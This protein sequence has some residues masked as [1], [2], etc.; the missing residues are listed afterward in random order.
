MTI[1]PESIGVGKCYLTDGNTVRRV[2]TVL[3]DRRIQYEWRGGHRA[4]WKA[5]ILSGR[6]FAQQ[7]ER[8]V[9]CDWTPERDNEERGTR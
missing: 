6:E 9:P 4:K 7:A 1:P 3:P 2:V 8:E 5:G